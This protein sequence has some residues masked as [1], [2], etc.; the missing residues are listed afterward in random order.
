VEHLL[1]LV[2]E[3]VHVGR[4]LITGKLHTRP[5]DVHGSLD[6]AALALIEVKCLGVSFEWFDVRVSHS[7]EWGS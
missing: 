1:L 7:A 2:D 5:G 4:S 6:V 3:F